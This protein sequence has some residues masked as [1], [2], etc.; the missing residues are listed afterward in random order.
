MKIKR[1][2]IQVLYTLLFFLIFACV[3]DEDDQINPASDR[4]K[5]LGSWNVTEQCNRDSYTVEIIEDPSNSAQVII[6]NFWLIGYQEEPPFAIVSGNSITIP[7]QTM[8]SN[9]TNEVKGSGIFDKDKIIW[10]YEV[11]D[12]AD[13]WKCNAEYSQ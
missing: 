9:H 12:G 10:D 3:P 13:L 7:L 6:K 2:R 11:N 8:C 5:F 4:D 1:F